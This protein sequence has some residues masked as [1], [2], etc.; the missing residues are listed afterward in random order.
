LA[1]PT[2]VRAVKEVVKVD[3]SVPGCPP[4]ADTI[5]YALAELA[6]GRIPELKGDKLQWN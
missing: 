1:T 6:Q 3:V 4:D 2:R 5:Y